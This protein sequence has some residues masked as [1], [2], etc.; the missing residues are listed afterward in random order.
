MISMAEPPAAGRSTVD[1][2]ELREP[3]FDPAPD[4]RFA[5]GTEPQTRVL[6]TV[7]DAVERR[8]SLVAITGE[9]GAGKTTF[10]LGLAKRFGSRTFLS[11][12]AAPPADASRFVYGLLVDFG[13]ASPGI[14]PIA[15]PALDDLRA[16]LER[17]L[18][19]LGPLQSHA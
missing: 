14:P 3:P 9:E 4:P 12:V 8:E 5:Q 15:V 7:V 1:Y 18:I 19:S 2:F 11:M 17:F 16:P 13:L 6:D 10:C